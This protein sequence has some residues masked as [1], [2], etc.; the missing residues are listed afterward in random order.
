MW[1]VMPHRPHPP[2]CRGYVFWLRNSL[3]DVTKWIEYRLCINVLCRLDYLL[4]KTTCCSRHIVCDRIQE[5]FL[6]IS[7]IRRNDIFN[8]R[9]FVNTQHIGRGWIFSTWQFLEIFCLNTSCFPRQGDIKGL[10]RHSVR[11]VTHLLIQQSE[12]V[13]ACETT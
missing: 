8:A 2:H 13:S 1:C 11:V 3:P 4:F 9:I 6:M 7:R 5:P 10:G 12:A